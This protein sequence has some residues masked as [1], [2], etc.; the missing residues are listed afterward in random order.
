MTA[1]AASAETTL[2]VSE[3]VCQGCVR[4]VESALTSVEGVLSASVSLETGLATIVGNAAA[5]TL[6][7][8]VKA[9]GRTARDVT[10]TGATGV[11]A[12]TPSDPPPA[13]QPKLREVSRNIFVSTHGTCKLRVDGMTCSRCSSAVEGALSQVPGVVWASVDLESALATVVGSA[14]LDALVGAVAATGKSARALPPLPA[15]EAMPSEGADGAAMDSEAFESKIQPK[16]P[17]SIP[18]IVDGVVCEGCCE[19]VTQALLSVEGVEYAAAIVEN[20]QALVFGTASIEELAAAVAATGN[21][22]LREPQDGGI[23]GKAASRKLVRILAADIVCN[24]CAAKV[25][26]VLTPIK[27]VYEVRIDLDKHR[28]DVVAEDVS[29]KMLVEV[30]AAVGFTPELLGVAALG[31]DAP[32]GGADAAGGG[33]ASGG[34][35]RAMLSVS[36]MHCASC[37]SVLQGALEALGGV[38][39]AS[40]SLMTSSAEIEYDPK[41]ITRETLIATSTGVGFAAGS[42]EEDEV[43]DAGL[44]HALAAKFWLRRFLGTLP[45]TLPVFFLS[46]ILRHLPGIK[47]ALHTQVCPGLSVVTLTLWLL[48]TPVQLCFATPFYRSALAA[49][50]RRSANMDT[51]VALGTSAAYAYSVTMMIV[52]LATRG[53]QGKDLETFETAAMLISF[54]LLGKFL[55]SSAKASASSAVSKLLTL[56]PPMALMMKRCKELDK[57]P[58]QVS[59]SEVRKGDVVK[60]LPGAAVAVDG[61]VVAGSSA[62]DEAMI[63]LDGT[64]NKARLGANAILGV[65]LAVAK[66]AAE[67]SGLPLYR[68]VGVG[69]EG[70][71]VT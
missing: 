68:Y 5:E 7:E 62:V 9:T 50:K 59:V 1:A 43:A 37:V 2:E 29:A 3:L 30:L 25:V 39:S 54:I 42:R 51:L 28:V 60:V 12:A 67:T 35:A 24:G 20:R 47:P 40:V 49:L 41:L 18:L 4:M 22:T 6:V 57:P 14:P 63:H 55:E 70:A 69:Q 66:A 19:T 46:M 34:R 36:G 27:G 16:Q 23:I 21:F 17:R 13:S 38:H 15:A 64:P 48:T 61:V 44:D 58:M 32:A 56:Q 10:G 26:S 65:S 33:A 8:T 71:E 11:R 53:A 31:A 45:F 52:S